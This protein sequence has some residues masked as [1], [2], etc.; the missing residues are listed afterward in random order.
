MGLLPDL[1]ALICVALLVPLAFAQAAA[2][3][4]SAAA[5]GSDQKLTP[6][7]RAI[8]LAQKHRCREALPLLEKLT[9]GIADK[10]V[11]Y[12]AEIATV[13][14]TIKV[15]DGRSTVTTLLALKHEFPEDPEVLYLTTQVF[16]TIAENSAKDLATLAPSSYQILELQAESQEQQ[17]KWDEAARM[18]RE[19]LEQNPRL[20]GIHLR[21]GRAVLSQQDSTAGAEEASKEFTAELAVDPYNSSAE[22]WL[23]EV[24]RISEKWDEAVLHFESAT[25]LDPDYSEAYLGQGM[26]ANAA[27]RYAEAIAPLERYVK[28]APN[29]PAGHYQL[30]IAYVRTDR[31][32]DSDREK[33]MVRKLAE[34]VQTDAANGS[35]QPH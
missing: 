30:S 17:H 7:D 23:G 1:R 6:V 29:D 27:K 10:Q 31:A 20:P 28:M 9:P 5:S 2:G 3:S 4:R 26:S 13:H 12:R 21:L 18:Y 14:C 25:K 16:L 15:K 19:I 35:N 34:K 32:E 22:F 11:R 24:A 33:D 8:E